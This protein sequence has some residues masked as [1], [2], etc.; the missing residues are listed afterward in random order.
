MTR[1]GNR[2]LFSSCFCLL[3]S[4]ACPTGSAR[5]AAPA[6]RYAVFLADEPV[7]KRFPSRGEI[8]SAAGAAWRSRVEA[9][10]SVARLQLAAKNI[11][12]TG[13]VST[14]LNAI[15]VIARP[16]SIA[17][18]KTISGVVGVV[19]LGQSRMLLNRATAVLGGSQAWNRVGGLAGAGAGIKIG[20][21]DSGIDQ[22]HPALQDSTLQTPSGFPKCNAVS[23]C[24]NFTNSK[25]IVARSY[26][27]MDAAGTA[28]DVASDSRPDDYSARDRVGHGTAVATAAAGNTSSLAVTINGMAPKAWVGNYKIA[29]SPGVNDSASDDALIQALEDAVNDGMDVVTTSFGRTATAGP[30][31]TGAACGN[32]AGV[33]CD[34]LAYAFEQAAEAGT[35]V[36]AAAG[37]AGEGGPYRTGRYPMYN[38]IS[39]P[40][41]APSV[42]AV[43]AVSN[44]H[45]FSPDVEVAGSGVP[46]NLSS[47]PAQ[48]TDASNPHGAYTEPL[49]DLANLGD[50]YGCNPFPQFSLLGSFAL[51]QRGPVASPC[52]FTAKMTNAAN[53][54]AAGAV[55]YDNVSETPFAP[56]GLSGFSQPV[57]FIGMS[58]GQNLKAFIDANPGYSVTINPS[59]TEVSIGGSTVLAGYSSV[60]PGLGTNGIK[61]D[62]IAVGGGTSNGD[63]IYLGTQ[64]YDP[65]GE[66]YSSLRYVAAGGTSFAA[67][68]AAGSAALVKQ[69]H[70]GY[71]S[72]QVKSALVDTARSVAT[73]D[74]G[75]GTTVKPV[76]IL[77]TG[78]G[79]VA[80]DLAIETNVT[81]VPSTVSF[82]SFAPGS[83]LSQ[84]Q[85]LTFTNTGTTTTSSGATTSA[86]L[87][88]TVLP[89][90]SASGATVTVS[91]PLLALAEGSSA[92]VTV[93]LSGK[94]SAGG[95]Y[96]GSI[97]IAG[98]ATVMHIPY[99]FM[100]PL[101]LSGTT[102]NLDA[103]SGDS[104]QA[105][106]GQVIPDGQVAFQLT[107]QN[108]VPIAGVPVTF[109]KAASS[110][111][112]TL[113][114]VSATTDS[115]GDA[116]A[117][118]T[119]GSQTGMYAVSASAGGQ[120]YQFTGNVSAPPA[121][122]TVLSAANG[123]SPVAPGSYAAIYGN[124][125]GYATD[126]NY[127]TLRLPLSMDHV[128]VSFDAPATGSLP[129]VSVPGYII[130][131]SP[132]Q[133][134][135]QVPWELQGYS[136]A[137]V[138]VTVYERGFGN[139]V[140]VPVASY[141]PAIFPYG[142]IAAAANV[143]NGSIITASNPAARGSY[144]ALF[145]N[146][147]GPVTNQP[148]SGNPAVAT[149]LSQTPEKP[150]VMIGGV[151]GKVNFSGLTPG[152]PGLYQV[153]VQV[154]ANIAAGMQPITVAIGGA[155]SSSLMLPVY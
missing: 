72:Q 57:L 75:F 70:S 34:P 85:T 140:A 53:A 65:L 79:L 108:G 93:G 90:S 135:V 95:L 9:A 44:T 116:F 10:Q 6:N 73:D 15:F 144:I 26:V 39:T 109:S 8:Q 103:F 148:A 16:A 122:S 25:V 12:I 24:L 110:V 134:N 106:A 92:T 101:G 149:P 82:G 74:D 61:P 54:G 3:L 81:V 29:G 21:L 143:T 78:S 121:T 130:Y 107:D 80:A 13:S 94:L 60:G 2:L 129:A 154:P 152:F 56:T 112:L 137:S 113:S 59:A 91:Q 55:F 99:M 41:D 98:A 66:L 128:T 35:I 76:G 118:V 77:Q 27:A 50:P 19:K 136:S 150:T 62:V 114:G 28:G 38:T 147:L 133:V 37:D 14:L 63:L 69:A 96:Y 89:V 151:V 52:T 33:P 87:S 88:F 139:V 123:T 132:S 146:G 43:G 105:I 97:N 153:N 58:D 120:T 67:P 71:T 18:I 36:L 32:A 102:V 155:T 104:D 68:L 141:A 111:P 11:R 31:D 117:M 115:Y 126:E 49:V 1:N 64:N 47:I 138:K 124:N 51:I 127:N 42:I 30:T 20:I 7:A 46:G 84:S 22:T 40:A 83:T 100:S 131:T 86:T 4:S 142:S 125:L 17:D 5:A 145:C 48:Y 23:D 45:G 119:I